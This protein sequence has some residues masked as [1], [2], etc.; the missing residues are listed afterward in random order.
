MLPFN[1]CVVASILLA[2]FSV[3][4][5]AIEARSADARV[6]VR[7]DGQWVVC[8]SEHFEIWC[9]L[10]VVEATT[11]A[12]RCEQLR[13]ELTRIWLETPTA[14][15]NRCA[16]VVSQNSTEYG[17][18]IGSPGNSSVGCTTLQTSNGEIT[19]RRVD[20]R[21][22]AVSWQT[23]ALAHEITHVILA[24][25][26]PGATLPLWADEGISILSEPKSTQA[27]RSD[28]LVKAIRSGNV[29]MLET[30]L[31]QKETP[32]AG[33][34]DSFYAQAGLL[35][36]MLIAEESPARFLEFVSC[37][38][39]TS[40]D[41]ALRKVYEIDGLQALRTRWQAQMNAAS[42]GQLLEVTEKA[43]MA[44]KFSA[45][46]VPVSSQDSNGTS[47]TQGRSYRLQP[48]PG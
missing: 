34:R 40:L 3:S 35:V 9:H 15:K 19:F 24:D 4:A 37:S 5:K 14:W 13:A 12:Q 48:Y 29:L 27:K 42:R 18:A 7:H 41:Q 11:L 21:A 45:G 47:P 2:S 17:R 1:Q 46:S 30:L 10:P 44:V 36:A 38:Q 32:P 23:S 31:S 6:N 20:V 39:E 22:D 8:Q 26:F 25:R 33:L 43:A 16:I 28:A